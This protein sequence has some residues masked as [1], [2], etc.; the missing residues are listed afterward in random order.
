MNL[1]SYNSKSAVFFGENCYGLIVCKSVEGQF[2]WK[3]GSR[4]FYL[5]NLEVIHAKSGLLS[6]KEILVNLTRI[7][8]EY[9]DMLDFA[10]NNSL[11]IQT[12]KL[13]VS[14]SHFQEFYHPTEAIIKMKTLLTDKRIIIPEELKSV[15]QEELEIYHPTENQTPLVSGLLMCVLQVQE[16]FEQIYIDVFREPVRYIY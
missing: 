5:K 2:L 13:P 4:S 8:G 6:E 12:I 9:R 10:C 16:F 14:D 15:F 1:S 11:M 7:S 3:S